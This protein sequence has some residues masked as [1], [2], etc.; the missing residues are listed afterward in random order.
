MADAMVGL[1]E[2]IGALRQELL[3]AMG[4]G[5]SAAMR[6]RLALVKLSMQVAV[7]RKRGQ[8]RL[9]CARPWWVVLPGDDADAEAAAGSGLE[10]R[11]WFLHQ[12][13]HDR[14]PGR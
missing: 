11:R 14:R 3:A 12:R 8:D 6:F 2:A 4:E 10:A 1:T 7:T 13:L 9:A 5:K